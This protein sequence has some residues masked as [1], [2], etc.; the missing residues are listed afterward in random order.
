[1]AAIISALGK[2]VRHVLSQMGYLL[3]LSRSR[4]NLDIEIHR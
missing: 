3:G 4:S 2:N 1:M